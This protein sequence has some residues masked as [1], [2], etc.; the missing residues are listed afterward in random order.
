MRIELIE[1]AYRGNEPLSREERRA[2]ARGRHVSEI[3]ETSLP[4][5]DEIS[6]L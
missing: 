5:S 4:S 6:S 3:S 2:I 1:P